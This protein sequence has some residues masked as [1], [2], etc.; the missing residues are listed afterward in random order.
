MER[1]TL[2]NI[3]PVTGENYHI[4]TNPPLTQEVRDRLRQKPS[5]TDDLVRIKL[6][7]YHTYLNDLLDYYENAI[8]INA[9]QDRKGVYESIE[10]GIVNPLPKQGQYKLATNN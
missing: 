8:H 6:G 10:H 2:R 7:S 1:L 3:D 9:D 5:D 4:L